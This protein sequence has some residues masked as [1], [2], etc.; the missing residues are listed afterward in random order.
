MGLGSDIRAEKSVDSSKLA[1]TAQNIER[2][3]LLTALVDTTIS[4]F[5]MRAGE[6]KAEFKCLCDS[7][8]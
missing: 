7:G 4:A 8:S 5:V 2:D 6:N 3:L 1:G